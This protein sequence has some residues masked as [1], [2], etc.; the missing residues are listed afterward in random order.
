MAI[1]ANAKGSFIESFKF[2]MDRI[3]PLKSHNALVF[4]IL[5]NLKYYCQITAVKGL[6]HHYVLAAVAVVVYLA[7][8]LYSLYLL[9]GSSHTVESF[10]DGLPLAGQFDH[11]SGIQH[12]VSEQM[13]ELQA[14]AVSPPLVHFVVQL[15]PLRGE[16]GQMLQVP[17]R[18][19]WTA[20]KHNKGNGVRPRKKITGMTAVCHKLESFKP[21]SSSQS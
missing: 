19:V 3:D 21:P 4:I 5:Y 9:H 17:P 18:Q 8:F 15:V 10:R 14:H 11:P 13:V 20:H 1:E 6:Q 16:D 12:A 7:C 2:L